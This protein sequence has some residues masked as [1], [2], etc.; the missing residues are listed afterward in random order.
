MQ[1]NG[2]TL[3][4]ARDHEAHLLQLAAPVR[5][6]PPRPLTRRRRRAWILRHLREHALR[7]PLDSRV[8]SVAVRVGGS[9]F[10]GRGRTVWRPR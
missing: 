4:T 10:R 3:Q 6:L 7:T 8:S 1:A 2:F 9:K 5:V